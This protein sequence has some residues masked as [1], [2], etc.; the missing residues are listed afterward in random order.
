[1]AARL[2]LF[3]FVAKAALN[4]VGGGFGGDFIIEVLPEIANDVWQWWG[5]DRPVGQL[6]KELQEV[7]QLAPA[8]AASQAEQAVAEEAAGR[9]ETEKA[10]LTAYLSLIPAAIRQSQRRASDPSGRTMSLGLSL[11]KSDDVLPLLPARLPRFKPG[12]RPLAPTVNLELVELLGAGGFGEVWK[13][14]NPQFDGFKPVALKFCLDRSAKDRL[15]GHEAAVL[16]QVMR[17][18]SHP[19]IVPLL[20]TF[21]GADPPCLEYEYVP[22]GDLS[23]IIRDARPNGGLPPRQAARIIEELAGV[24][25]FAHRLTPPVVHRDLK[26]ANILVQ[27]TS[28]GKW[29]FRVTDFGIGGVAAEQAIGKSRLGASHGHLLVSCLIG[30][31]TPLYASPQQ[32]QG[33]LPDPR[34]DVYSLGV[35]WHQ[36]LTG[37]LLAGAQSGNAWKKH[38][39]KKGM[40]TPLID[41][42]EECINYM[43]ADRPV[44]ASELAERIAEIIKSPLLPPSPPGSPFEQDMKDALDVLRTK[45][46]TR[47]YFERQGPTR[48]GAWQAAAQQ[49]DAIAQWL[50]A[51]CLQEGTGTQKDAPAAVSWLR[52]A[53]ESG[54][55]AAQSDLGDCYSEGEGVEADSTEAFRLYTKAAEQGF[56]EAQNSLGVCYDDGNGVEQDYPQAIS[57][58]RKAAEQGWAWAQ[59]NLGYCSEYGRGVKKNWGEAAKWYRKAA[60]QDEV[61]AQFALGYCYEQ[62]R[63]VEQDRAQAEQWYRKAA[64]QGHKKAK[65]ALDRLLKGEKPPPSDKAGYY[66]LNTNYSNDHTDHEDMLQNK[67]AAAYFAPWKYKIEQLSKGDTVFLYQSGVGVVGIG[68]ASGTLHK[69][70]YHGDPKHINEEYFMSLE[71]FE[72]AEPPVTAATIKEVTGRNYVFMQTMFAVEADAATALIEYIQKRSTDTGLSPTETSLRK[73]QVRILAALAK[74]TK[75]L[76]RKEI[77]EQAPCDEAWLTSWMGVEDDVKRIGECF[78]SLVTLGYVWREKP[79]GGP[80]VHSI[81]EA[82]RKALAA[83]EEAL[84]KGGSMEGPEE[85]DP[86]EAGAEPPGTKPIRERWLTVL[87]L[88]LQKGATSP[89]SAVKFSTFRLE[90]K[91]AGGIMYGYD[92]LS[93]AGLIE[94]LK[95]ED[96]AGWFLCLTAAGRAALDA[97]SA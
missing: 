76:T 94:W 6:R 83:T 44:N 75:P 78:P 61:D 86:E 14:R 73:P 89:T 4:Y 19:G 39:A 9:P 16:N 41:L 23:A 58:Y 95:R 96:E 30:S 71:G 32:V 74:A 12:D 27:R 2:A 55:A 67:K 15:L 21:L 62:G 11:V 8:E 90:A 10:D 31:Y 57:W 81:T 80:A 85:D 13:A 40:T 66:F 48:I 3:K 93:D 70:A 82:G 79:D 59:F 38:L 69:A 45:W 88:L 65:K 33:G 63:G 43:P 52:R 17:Q 64:D 51:R 47:T 35:I 60:D 25:G 84:A 22:G 54:L 20:N 36:L 53:A 68:Y 29:V 46:N 26:P 37:E 77:A 34:D 24:V 18:G 92:G 28:D 91:A 56:A 5:K 87:R 72:R 7:A 42:L 49:G 50:L 1:M 97:E